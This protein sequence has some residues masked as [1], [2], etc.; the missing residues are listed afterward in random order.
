MPDR[1]L[2]LVLIASL[3]VW[4]GCSISDSISSPFKSSSDSSGSSSESSATNES[5]FLHD[6]ED[7]TA[8]YAR[9]KGDFDTFMQGVSGLAAKRGITN[10]EA[11]QNTF[12]AIGKGLRKAQ[13]D[14]GTLEA[15]IVNIA[16]GDAT[17]AASIRKGFGQ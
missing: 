5:K 14:Q 1:V 7:Y 2:P 16:K 15:Y 17:K 10:W 12:V 6:V 4:S 3:L 8:S 11:D 13:V 9:G